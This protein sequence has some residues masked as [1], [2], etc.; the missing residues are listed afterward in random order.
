M[1]KVLPRNVELCFV[2]PA[3]IGTTA[4]VEKVFSFIFRS[5]QPKAV[6]LNSDAGLFPSY[7]LYNSFLQA[8]AYIGKLDLENLF[9]IEQHYEKR[10]IRD[11]Q[12]D[13]YTKPY[14][15]SEER[16]RP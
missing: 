16:E 2:V 4:K 7:Q 1:V 10:I 6:L 8:A 12:F 5:I 11:S 3:D 15:W 13:W 14:Q 9:V